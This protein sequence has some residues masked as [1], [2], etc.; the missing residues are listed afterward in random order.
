M[1]AATSRLLLDP[2]ENEVNHVHDRD[3]EPHRDGEDGA[4]PVVAEFDAF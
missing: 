4:G 3:E 1:T 2:D